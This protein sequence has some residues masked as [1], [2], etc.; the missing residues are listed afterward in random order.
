MVSKI[1]KN[2]PFNKWLLRGKK[3]RQLPTQLSENKVKTI[4]L[5]TYHFPNMFSVWI[6]NK[7]KTWIKMHFYHKVKHTA[8]PKIEEHLIV[9]TL[10]SSAFNITA[11]CRDIQI[12]SDFICASVLINNSTEKCKTRKV[13]NLRMWTN[14]FHMGAF[15]TCKCFWPSMPANKKIY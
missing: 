6:S 2:I 1:L 11:R 14:V 12:L 15:D 13:T 5:C 10:L 7:G 9:P 8:V 4:S 3:Q